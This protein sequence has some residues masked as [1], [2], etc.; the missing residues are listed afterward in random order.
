MTVESTDSKALSGC[1]YSECDITPEKPMPL[2]GFY[3]EKEKS[4]GVLKPLM[5]QT[6]VWENG[7]GSRF[8]LITVDSLGFTPALTNELRDKAADSI[9][10]DR[11]HVM[12]CFS[13]THAA[14]DAADFSTGYYAMACER[15]L[16]ALNE[17]ANRIEP[18]RAGWGNTE[19]DIGVNRRQTDKDIDRRLGILKICQRDTG[20]LMLIILRVTAHGNVLKRDN[21]SVSPDYFGDARELAE[22]RFDCPV[23]VIQGAAG[24]VAPKYFH[25]EETPVDATG[26]KYVRSETALRDMGEAVVHGMEETVG[27]IIMDDCV[28]DAYSEYITLYSEVPDEKTAERVA[29]EAAENCWIDGTA[30]LAEARKLRE[31]KIVRQSDNVEVQYFR[32]GEGCLCGVP[33]EIMNEFALRATEKLNDPYFYLNGYTNGCM[34][35][36]PTEEEF[37]RGGY[38]VYWSLLIYYI[39]FGRVFPFDR[40]SA[41]MLIDFAVRNCR[42]FKMEEREKSRL[43]FRRIGRDETG[44]ISELF[45]GVFMTEP[46]NDDWSDPEQLHAYLT[47]LTGQSNSLTYGLFEDGALIGVSMGHIKH[48]YSGTEYCIEEFCIRKDRQGQGI[49]SHFLREIEKATA[50]LGLKQ[51]FLQTES[52]VPAY[53]FYRKNGFHELNGHV[54]FAKRL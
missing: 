37:D 34:T 10:T 47:D 24:N 33:Y 26:E 45:A 6:A 53:E 25:S 18:I 27:Q 35:Y 49:G 13:H 50:G 16:K 21:N 20:K 12:V 40:E 17:A 30:W 52:N 39:Y 7:D 32:I 48:W 15:I 2:I 51:I 9:G 4:E 42:D 1:G 54:S 29:A 8:C 22:N 19:I 43:I 5:A 41:G 31:Q 46:W 11:Q 28:I 36:F 38:E 14:P 3:R 44:R 23:M